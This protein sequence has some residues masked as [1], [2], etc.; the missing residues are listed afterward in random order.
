MRS[1]EKCPPPFILLDS[2]SLKFHRPQVSSSLFFQYNTGGYPPPV[3]FPGTLYFETS[4]H[5]S[6]IIRLGREDIA[7][8]EFLRSSRPTILRKQSRYLSHPQ[9][10]LII[11][12][13]TL[14]TSRSLLTQTSCPWPFSTNSR[15][16]RRCTEPFPLI[17][18]LETS[19][20][21]HVNQ[22]GLSFKQVRTD[23]QR[24]R[25]VGS[26]RFESLRYRSHY[27]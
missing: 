23:Y 7:D 24:L 8:Y 19:D 10:C 27:M 13:L 21:V 1:F 17:F 15:F 4:A 22:D 18:R 9:L 26:Q 3:S 11:Q 16:C 12:I 2:S 6:Y 5:M 25:H 14:M 20:D